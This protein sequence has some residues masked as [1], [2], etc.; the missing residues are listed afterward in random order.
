MDGADQREYFRIED[1]LPIE[2]RSVGP[3]EFARLEDI[4]RYNPACTP[5]DK[6]REMH[7]PGCAAS[8][9]KDRDSGLYAYLRVLERKLDMILDLLGPGEYGEPYKAL[10]TSVNISG[11]GIKFASHEPLSEGERVELRVALP[12]APYSR[13]STLC[14]VV[15]AEPLAEREGKEWLIALKFLVVNDFDRDVLVNYVF[16]KER[17]KLRSGKGG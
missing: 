5:M 6:S 17:E 10:Y 4:I 8:Q 9:E 13:I 14:E 12:L 16:A 15:R 11:A 3:E 2:F 7:F 1:R